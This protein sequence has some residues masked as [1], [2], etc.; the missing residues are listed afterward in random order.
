M[1][2]LE[3]RYHYSSGYGLK[4]KVEVSGVACNVPK[5]VFC[6]GAVVGNVFFLDKWMRSVVSCKVRFAFCMGMAVGRNFFCQ[7]HPVSLTR[8]RLPVRCPTCFRYRAGFFL[9]DSNT[10]IFDLKIRK[11]KENLKLLR[12]R[13]KNHL[14]A[15]RSVWVWLCAGFFFFPSSTSLKI[16]LVNLHGCD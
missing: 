3:Y 4:I 9:V 13:S 11:T 8:V 6:M 14:L 16:E 12:F 10:S 5:F 15:Q 1:L 2:R 7:Q